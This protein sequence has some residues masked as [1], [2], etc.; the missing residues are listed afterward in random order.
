MHAALPVDHAGP[1]G[2]LADWSRS[3]S[4]LLD[5][6]AEW[7][8]FGRALVGEGPAGRWESQVLVEGMHCAACA[9][10]VEAALLKV[11]GVEKAEVNATS[12]RARVVWSAAQV[13]P[14]ACADNPF[15]R[16][17]AELLPCSQPSRFTFSYQTLCGDETA[18]A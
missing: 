18:S 10:A 13:W 15:V 5:D 4:A 8:G 16:R 2:P 3:D 1:A 14:S 12:R 17:D 6:A 11:P 9:F 7:P